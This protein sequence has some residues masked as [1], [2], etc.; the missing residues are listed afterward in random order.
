MLARRIND[1]LLKYG[2]KEFR[3]A[4]RKKLNLVAKQS[5]PLVYLPC[6]GVTIPNDTKLISDH[7]RLKHIGDSKSANKLDKLWGFHPVVR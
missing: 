5:H 1:E 3:D 6:C 7:F 4:N 2:P